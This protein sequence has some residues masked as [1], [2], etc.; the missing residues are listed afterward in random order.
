MPMVDEE[1]M[2]SVYP[3]TKKQCVNCGHVMSYRNK[4]TA[5]YLCTEKAER[6]EK[7]YPSRYRR[8]GERRAERMQAQ[9]NPPYS[10][11]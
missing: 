5:C 6:L 9:K 10:A 1:S 3:H 11:G 7:C 4:G 2:A 8:T